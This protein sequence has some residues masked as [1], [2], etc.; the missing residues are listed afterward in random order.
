MPTTAAVVSRESQDIAVHLYSMVRAVKMPPFRG[1][2]ISPRRVRRRAVLR[3]VM[4]L[5]ALARQPE[6]IRHIPG[7]D[8]LC[9][10]E[11][12]ELSAD[13]LTT[14][15]CRVDYVCDS[16]AV[17]YAECFLHFGKDGFERGELLL[18]VGHAFASG[19]KVCDLLR[20]HCPGSLGSRLL[21]EDAGRRG[22]RAGGEVDR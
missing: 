5:V 8:E 1:G 21:D 19:V 12:M 2:A 20:P 22:D 13:N 16:R 18:Q 3:L 9:R 4:I 6:Q 7:G 17:T 15:L 10:A 11:D 14:D